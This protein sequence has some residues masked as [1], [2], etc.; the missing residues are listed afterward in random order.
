MKK[1]EKKCNSE[2]FQTILDGRKTFELRLNDFDIEEGDIFVLKEW[3]TE[4]KGYT[5]RTL[6]KKVGFVGK[7]KM[8]DLAKF[9]PIEE[10]EHKG[11]QIISLK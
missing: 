5:G 4:T 1:V 7:W 8:R 10:F 9:N 3:N 11:F 2:Y 6:E